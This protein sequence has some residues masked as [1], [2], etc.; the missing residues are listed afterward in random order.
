MLGGLCLEVLFVFEVLHGFFFWQRNNK[1]SE[2]PCSDHSPVFKLGVVLPW[3]VQIPVFKWTFC[4]WFYLGSSALPNEHR[5][6]QP[7]AWDTTR[8]CCPSS[9]MI[10]INP[11]HQIP[12]PRLNEVPFLS[13]RGESRPCPG[14]GQIYSSVLD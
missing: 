10:P 5:R 7:R 13:H 9:K 6:A 2:T 8:S 12:P 11:G 3:P 14:E 1:N 4:A